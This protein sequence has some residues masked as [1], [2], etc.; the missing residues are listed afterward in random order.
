MSNI[1]KRIRHKGLDILDI[2]IINK[3]NFNNNPKYETILPDAPWL[4]GRKRLLLKKY[5]K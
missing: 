5:L 4:P 2:G 1:V 3:R